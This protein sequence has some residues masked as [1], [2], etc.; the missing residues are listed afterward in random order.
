M[1]EFTSLDTATF[2]GKFTCRWTWLAS[3]LNSTSPA[4]KSSHT[5]RMIS[6]DVLI[7]ENQAVA[8]EN[9]AVK[10]FARTY[11]AKSVHDAG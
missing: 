9:L 11:L 2:G 10:G 4:S 7:R 8:V 3:L 6:S 1:R 5:A